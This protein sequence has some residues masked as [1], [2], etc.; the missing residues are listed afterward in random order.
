MAEGQKECECKYIPNN[1]EQ[2]HGQIEK[3]EIV[4]YRMFMFVLKV[5]TS[6]QRVLKVIVGG[7]AN[8]IEYYDI[9]EHDW[10]EHCRAGITCVA[11]WTP[12]DDNY[13]CLQNIPGEDVQ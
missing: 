2:K 9:F 7:T 12:F 13:Q 4:D 1:L 10:S 8:L 5:W 11:K 6:K 3:I